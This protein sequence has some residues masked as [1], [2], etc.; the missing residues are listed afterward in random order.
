MQPLDRHAGA[1]QQFLVFVP[2]GDRVLV[3]VH[4]REGVH[5]AWTGR[6][7]PSSCVID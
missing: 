4:L 3:A 6:W 5:V 7:R 1:G 2:A